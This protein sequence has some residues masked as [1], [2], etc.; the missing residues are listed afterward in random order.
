MILVTCVPNGKGT[1]SRRRG[2]G[3]GV[4]RLAESRGFGAARKIDVPAAAAIE[5]TP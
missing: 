2:L 3:H 1:H 4:A 5:R